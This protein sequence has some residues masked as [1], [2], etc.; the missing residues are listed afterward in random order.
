MN[1]AQHFTLHTGRKIP[2]LAFGTGTTYFERNDD[3]TEG[4]LKA[5]K[6]GFRYIDTAIMYQTEE[7]VGNAI[8]KLINEGTNMNNS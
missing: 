4:I 7:G 1:L 3:V 6:V 8:K 5:F 2:V